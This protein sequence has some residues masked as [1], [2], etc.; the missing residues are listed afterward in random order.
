M[1]YYNKN[2]EKRNLNDMR[3]LDS[4]SS[5]NIYCNRK[6]IFKKYFNNLCHSDKIN[7]DIFV[8]IFKKCF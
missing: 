8:Y 4:G 5:A 6:I 1:S 7:I 3:Y 2:C